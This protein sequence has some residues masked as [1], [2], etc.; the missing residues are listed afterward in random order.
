M[1][2]TNWT[3]ETLAQA[4][5]ETLEEILLNGSPPDWEPL[6]GYIYCGWNHEPVARALSGAKFKKGFA[7]KDG[8]FMGTTSSS[9]RTNGVTRASGMSG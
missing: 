9:F 1:A 4:E 5:R 3:F 8:N 6:V 2:N 7:K